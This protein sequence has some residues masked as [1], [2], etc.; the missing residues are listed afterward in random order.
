[1][2]LD[3][4]GYSSNHKRKRKTGSRAN[5]LQYRQID[6]DHTAGG[7]TQFNVNKIKFFRKRNTNEA[8]E[9]GVLCLYNNAAH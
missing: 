1:M 5:W 3:I 2:Y 9:R 7:T 8:K 4:R 6:I